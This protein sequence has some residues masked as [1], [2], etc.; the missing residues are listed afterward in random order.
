MDD[1]TA[2]RFG[3][4]QVDVDQ[5]LIWVYK[6]QIAWLVMVGTVLALVPERRF[7][8]SYQFLLGVDGGRY[9][10]AGVNLA[11]AG[12]LTWALRRNNRKYMAGGMRVAGLTHWGV[13][14]LL[15]IGA[16]SGPT[17]VLGWLYAFYVGSHMLT[18]SVLLTRRRYEK[19]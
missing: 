1:D 19:T 2:N 5:I 9:L 6:G 18:Q 4:H 8:S 10:L 3:L 7:G 16:L 11:C 14:L 15:G 17:G 13:A 12:I